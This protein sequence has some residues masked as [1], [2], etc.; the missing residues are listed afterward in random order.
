MGC[1]FDKFWHL[2]KIKIGENVC[3]ITYELT[4]ERLCSELC[5]AL[6]CSTNVL[7][8]CNILTL[9]WITQNESFDSVTLVFNFS[10]NPKIQKSHENNLF[11]WLFP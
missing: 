5:P 3:L 11:S 10:Y 7:I 9:F 6:K 2:L 1:N 4:T 8:L